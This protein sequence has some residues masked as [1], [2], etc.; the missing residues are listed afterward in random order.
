MAAETKTGGKPRE[1]REIEVY[2]A[3]DQDGEPV[4][5]YRDPK[6]ILEHLNLVRGTTSKTLLI[7]RNLDHLNGV[8]A[9]EYGDEDEAE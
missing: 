1:Y 6:L 8:A 9:D 5:A 3:F 2:V 7:R 4:A